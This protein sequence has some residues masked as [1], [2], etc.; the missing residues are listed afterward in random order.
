MRKSEEE[1]E[2]EKGGGVAE[3][4]KEPKPDD[5]DGVA[6]KHLNKRKDIR[7]STPRICPVALADP[8]TAIPMS[9]TVHS[10]NT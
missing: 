7:M 4:K 10:V 2:E 8:F 3:R 1:E 6:E 9:S 5:R